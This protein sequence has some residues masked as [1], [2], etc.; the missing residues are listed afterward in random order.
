MASVLKTLTGRIFFFLPHSVKSEMM[1][2]LS[3]HLH[4]RSAKPLVIDPA[5]PCYLNLGSGP[6]IIDGFVNIDFFGL[7]GIDFGADLRYPLLI[8]DASVDGILCEHTIEHLTYTEA[9]RLIAECHRI[10][11]P[12]GVLRV[13]VPD[14]S[15]FID[16]YAAGDTAWYSEWE[17]LMYIESSDP[18]RAARTLGTPMEAISFVTQEYGHRSCWDYL[19]MKTHL[20]ANGF[21]E[22]VR[23]EFREGRVPSILRDLDAPDRKHVS[24]Y[25]EATK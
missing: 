23:R 15:L 6:S 13:I 16:R 22:V 14:V 3:S 18:V 2:E 1:F 10:L 20:S 21:E 5:K 24:L 17:R 11:K 25:A 4:R 9:D 19:T 8:P 12:G 7:S